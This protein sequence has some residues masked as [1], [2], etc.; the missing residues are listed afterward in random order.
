[1]LLISVHDKYVVCLVSCALESD[2]WAAQL[3]ALVFCLA[4]TVVMI[5]ACYTNSAV[6]SHN[7]LYYGVVTFD[8]SLSI[9]VWLFQVLRAGF[10][11]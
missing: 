11:V 8:Y 5:I 9:H 7:L 6:C 2:C 10:S 3:R 1:M 4:G